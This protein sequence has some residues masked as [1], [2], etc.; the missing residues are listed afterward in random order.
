MKS[1]SLIVCTL[2]V[3][4]TALVIADSHVMAQNPER[5]TIFLPMTSS[6]AVPIPIE[7]GS[8]GGLWVSDGT[9]IG[10]ECVA[11][12]AVERATTLHEWKWNI[13]LWNR[14]SGDE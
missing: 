6:N 12:I 4:L 10:T 5:S 8:F 7:G 9:S 3:A 2:L 14:R 13:V 1:R 11:V